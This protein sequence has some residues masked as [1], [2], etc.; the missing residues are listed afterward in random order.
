[1][2]YGIIFLFIFSGGVFFLTG[3]VFGVIFMKM[4]LKRKLLSTGKS[5]IANVKSCVLSNFRINRRRA[6]FVE[7][8]WV[9]ESGIPHAYKSEPLMYDP[10]E[11][12]YNNK[13]EV[14]VNPNNYNKYCVNL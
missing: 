11:K 14:F 1:M 12:I 3:I 13:V 2:K 5:V 4:L 10:T 6:Y 9:D 8:E 7:C